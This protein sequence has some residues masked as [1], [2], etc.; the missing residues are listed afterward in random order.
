MQRA[1][2]IADLRVLARKR[3]PRGLFEYVDRGAE[4]ERALANN[5]AALERV[6]LRP[7]VLRNVL[8][9]STATTLFGRAQ[10]LPLAISPTAVAGMLWH[11]G[12]VLAARAA[13][14]AGIPFALSTASVSSLE[15]VTGKSGGP[16]WFQLYV[17]GDRDHMRSLI[18]RAK[19]AGCEALLLTVDTAV[20]AKREY[21]QRNGFGV[22]IKYNARTIFDVATHPRWMMNVLGGYAAEGGMPR[23]AHYPE[24]LSVST[25]VWTNANMLDA[26]IDWETVKEIRDLWQGPF[27]IK[28]VLHPEDAALAVQHGADGVVV[29]NHGGRNLDT[30]LA[31]IEAL[32]GIV[33]AVAGRIPVLVDGAFTR[34]GDIIKALALGA[35]TVMV[36]RAA[37]WGVAAGGER[38]A[39]RALAILREEIDRVLGQ[40]GCTSLAEL[41]RDFIYPPLRG[42]EY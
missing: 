15:H 4:D 16:I 22:P 37:L 36:G 25:T 6:R 26:S 10:K 39:A 33:D 42:A 21:N 28:G 30:A 1:Y 2:N 29:S 20:I 24:K 11:D 3:L 13:R 7:R 27:L 19:A 38:G 14:A 23:M 18:G 41:N 31:T 5:R 12:E 8:K 34:G 32:P 9:R 40:L 17:F 35:A